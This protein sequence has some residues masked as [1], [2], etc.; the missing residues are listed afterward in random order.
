MSR[1]LR[2]RWLLI[3]LLFAAFIASGLLFKRARDYLKVWDPARARNLH[4]PVPVRTTFVSDSQIDE[5]IG[6]TGLTYPSQQESIQLGPSKG[7]SALAPLSEIAIK[8]IHVHEGDYVKK[9][10]L[11]W[12]MEDKYIIEAREQER[13]AVVAAKA[14]LDKVTEQIKHNPLLRQLNLDAANANARYRADDMTARKQEY[15]IY[16]KVLGDTKGGVSM[17]QTLDS[18]ATYIASIYQQVLSLYTL[19]EAKVL[20]VVGPLKDAEELANANNLYLT[21]KL[22]FDL[23][24]HD[25][26]RI[27]IASSLDG[28]I[29]YPSKIE[30]VPGQIVYLNQVIMQVLKLAPIHIILD[31]PQERIDDV[32]IGQEAECILDSFPKEKF[33][34]KVIRISP[35][36]NPQLRVLPVTVLLDNPNKG[37]AEKPDHR[38]KAGTSA[39]VRLKTDKKKA[40]TL[41]PTAVLQQGSKA[42]VFRVDKEGDARIA[43]IQE[44]ITGHILDTEHL[45]IKKGLNLGDEVVLYND[46]YQ[47]V[48]TL[49]EKNYL[50]DG[51]SVNPDWQQWAHRKK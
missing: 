31:F 27:K 47:N 45:E 35:Q 2:L 17:I 11:L 46:F 28:Y 12:E 33:T 40:N 13:A 16:K 22:N 3:G 34:G 51:E 20:M 38:I 8:V 19:E 24:E 39:F 26:N 14:T 41:P 37:T 18:F 5:Y 7:L 6:C 44:V 9:G 23:I 32:H 36:V 10:Q 29:D 30:P 49:G 42:M 48:G 4:N 43:R 25:A 1:L 21:A 50:Q 15:E